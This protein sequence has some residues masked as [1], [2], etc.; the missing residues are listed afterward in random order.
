M[1]LILSSP[2][3]WVYQVHRAEWSAL[4]RR[5]SSLVNHKIWFWME[6]EAASS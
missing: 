3:V 6:A 2:S 4:D 1:S 5:E